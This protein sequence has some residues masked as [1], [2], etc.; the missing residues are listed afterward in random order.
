M[1][2]SAHPSIHPSIDDV[3]IH[4][5]NVNV[6]YVSYDHNPTRHHYDIF[7]GGNMS[8]VNHHPHHHHHHPLPSL[9][10]PNSSQQRSCAN[11]NISGFITR[12]KTSIHPI[13]NFPALSRLQETSSTQPN[14]KGKRCC[15][16]WPG[17][18]IS[19]GV[20]EPD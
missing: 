4:G 7:P 11:C 14:E 2:R 8:G 13:R 17:S 10:P 15:Q 6:S 3:F 12:I 1:D 5:G 18:P 19:L 16:R 20:G 9:P